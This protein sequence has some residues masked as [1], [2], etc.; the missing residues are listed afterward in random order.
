M[1]VHVSPHGLLPMEKKEK[2]KKKRENGFI[3]FYVIKKREIPLHRFEGVACEVAPV[4]FFLFFLVS[5]YWKNFKK[6]RKNVGNFETVTSGLFG[7]DFY[8]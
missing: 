5:F 1:L 7:T 6:R 3:F 4:F 2:E 8:L